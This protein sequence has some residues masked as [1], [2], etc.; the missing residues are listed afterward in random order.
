MVV[1]ALSRC[2]LG[3]SAS[4]HAIT[5]CRPAWLEVVHQSYQTDDHT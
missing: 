4:L 1:D 5:V 2:P 3:D